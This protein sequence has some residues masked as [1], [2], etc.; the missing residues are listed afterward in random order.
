MRGT[1]LADTPSAGAEMTSDNP[2]FTSAGSNLVG[3]N[4]D[5]IQQNLVE[6]REVL[7]GGTI[8]G[9]PLTADPRLGPLQSNGGLTPT[10]AL[11]T[12]SPAI[13]AGA[14]FGLTTDQ[15]GQPRP[16][17]FAALANAGDGSDIGAFE[18]GNGEMPAGAGTS[19]PG[20]PA[21]APGA[22]GF[23]STTLITIAL[24]SSGVSATTRL[25][26]V[27]TN[28]N[29]FSVSGTIAG[30]TTTA[31]AAKRR[32]RR[33]KLKAASFTIA[34]HAKTKVRLKLPAKLV[35]LLKRR[36]KLSLRLKVTVRDPAGQSRTVSK[37]VAP[38]LKKPKPKRKR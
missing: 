38:R 16:S 26:I 5:A 8:D 2:P 32:A 19:G 21:S 6:S 31:I 34:P 7:V 24:E 25:V 36:G 35:S 20:A 11:G 1:L 22:T 29:G 15:R 4:I 13:D 17:D 14:A 27:I 10:H 33:V 18:L 12:G 23:G 9:L 30:E 3:A 37:T 28:A